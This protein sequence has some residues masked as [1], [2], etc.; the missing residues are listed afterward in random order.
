MKT[1]QR[2]ILLRHKKNGGVV[3]I[4]TLIALII[5]LI[6]AVALV[7]SFDASLIA[8]G[9]VSFKRDLNNE[10]DHGIAAAITAMSSGALATDT[11]LDADLASANYSS[12]RLD[13]N[14][15]GIP[16]VLI[17][18]TLFASA[19]MSSSLDISP[20]DASGNSL[21][22]T[23]R[24]VIDRQC[25]EAGTFSTIKYDSCIYRVSDSGSGSVLP[26]NKVTVNDRAIYRISVRVKGPHD[27]YSFVQA[28]VAR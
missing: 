5:L 25:S 26:A 19:G 24:Y 7:R 1:N 4:M 6:T 27:T 22:V 10:A 9:N 13:S 18:D 14:N 20:T 11:T 2:A 21:G 3:L 16:L 28:T 23:V 17:N 8:A 12:S 15:Q